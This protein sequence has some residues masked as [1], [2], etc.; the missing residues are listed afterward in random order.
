MLLEVFVE[1]ARARQIHRHQLRAMQLPQ[2]ALQ[3]EPVETADYARDIG[4]VF[5]PKILHAT[6]GLS[7]RCRLHQRRSYHRD[8]GVQLFRL[9][10]TQYSLPTSSVAAPPR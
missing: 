8:R 4:P 7:D 2:R 5:R 9:L 3:P 1:H 10:A 6:A